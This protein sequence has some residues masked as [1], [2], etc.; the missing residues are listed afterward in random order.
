M[1][2]CNVCGVYI[3]GQ[4]TTE[5]VMHKQSSLWTASFL[6]KVASDGE[7]VDLEEDE[8]EK[9]GNESVLNDCWLVMTSLFFHM[10]DLLT[11]AIWHLFL[12]A[13]SVQYLLKDG[14]FW[15][16]FGVSKFWLSNSH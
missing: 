1:R 14:V 4:Y 5:L 9:R 2:R 8:D 16:L 13:L 3:F 12:S 7:K 15:Y 6:P 10:Q 11:V